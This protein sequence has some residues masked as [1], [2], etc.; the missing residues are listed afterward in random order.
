MLP[1]VEGSYCVYSSSG[2]GHLGFVHLLGVVTH[3]AVHTHT[4]GRFGSLWVCVVELLPRVAPIGV[5]MSKSA[6]QP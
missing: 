6:S 1:G 4:K 5:L 2:D 3:S